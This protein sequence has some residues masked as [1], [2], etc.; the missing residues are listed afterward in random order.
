MKRNIVDKLIKLRKDKH[1]TQEKLAEKLDISR[2]KVSS[3]ET[4]R[5]EMSITEAIKLAE[6][7]DVSLDNL[8]EIDDINEEQYIDISEKFIKN[9]KISLKQ[10]IEVIEC[11]KECLKKNNIDELYEKYKNDTKCD[12]IM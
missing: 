1:M 8:F 6:I 11:I 10:K 3:W 5:R 7:Y 4:N 9:K 12:K 2:A